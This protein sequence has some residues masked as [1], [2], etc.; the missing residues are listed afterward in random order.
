MLKWYWLGCALKKKDTSTNM[1]CFNHLVICLSY[2]NTIT[3]LFFNVFIFL[4]S[5]LFKSTALKNVGGFQW[6]L[7]EYFLSSATLEVNSYTCSPIQQFFCRA[8]DKQQCARI[9]DL[10]M[11]GDYKMIV[12]VMCIVFHS[13]RCRGNALC[14][15]ILC[16]WF[17]FY[18]ENIIFDILVNL[19]LVFVTSRR[20]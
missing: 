3:S 7:C 14:F 17:W 10:I 1:S 8:L 15:A 6:D 11:T 13:T 5:R 18:P 9:W 20:I 4:V 12:S 16:F 2:Y 19:N